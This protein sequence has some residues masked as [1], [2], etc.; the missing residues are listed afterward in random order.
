MI[1]RGIPSLKALVAP[2]PAAAA[3]A[4]RQ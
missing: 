2:T 1:D 4:K 3:L